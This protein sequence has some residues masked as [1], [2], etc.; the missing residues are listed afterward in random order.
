MAN[1]PSLSLVI[2]HLDYCNAILMDLP[3]ADISHLQRIQNICAKTV[4]DRDRYESSTN[5][6]HDLHWLPI[7]KR[8]QHIVLTFVHKAL[9]NKAPDYIKTLLREHQP[10]REG[11]RS[12]A[13]S[14]KQLIVPRTYRKTFATRLFSC[15]APTYRNNLPMHLKIIEDTETFKKQRPIYTSNEILKL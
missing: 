5:C 1:N 4:L 9:N 3:D 12:E 14:Y 7:Q 8:I 2:S 15:I 13:Q 11:L 10:R 6:L